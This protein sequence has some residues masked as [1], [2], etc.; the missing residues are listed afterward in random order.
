MRKLMRGGLV[1]LL[2][3]PAAMVLG[4]HSGGGSHGGGSS[5][6]GGS[7]GSGG[8]SSGGSHGGNTHG[9]GARIGGPHSGS[10][11]G[12]G[13][14]IGGSRGGGDHGGGSR[15]RSEHRGSH[16]RGRHRGRGWVVFGGPFWGPWDWWIWGCP[17]DPGC[18]G[19]PYVPDG[20]GEPG[21]Q[22]DDQDDWGMVDTEIW[23]D[24][25]RVY[26]EG[27]YI[28]A[29]EDFDGSRGFLYLRPG[30]YTLEFRLEGFHSASMD[31]NVEAGAKI[32][33]NRKL[34]RMRGSTEVARAK[35]PLPEGGLRRYW[36]KEDGRLVAYAGSEEAVRIRGDSDEA[37]DE[38]DDDADE[39][40][41]QAEPPRSPSSA[42]LQ[43]SLEPGD[44][45]VYLDDHYMG[46][47]A[48]ISRIEGGIP[49]P[50]GAHTITVT[51]PGFKS[52][53]LRVE[54]SRGES[55]SVK[56]SLDK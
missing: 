30:D 46:T 14:R 39:D 8:S 27:R 12:G 35:P 5:S 52:K 32:E 55:K 9:G 7:H 22:E 13:S 2:L 1:L 37:D 17:Y 56:L 36:G 10:P 34:H 45:V 42:R 38:T 3:V 16:D 29:A 28:G 47:A 24:Q 41:E 23:P 19:P 43:L 44:G 21:Y 26:L 40:S 6:G 53:T 4:Q 49:V 54:L 25:A 33:L 20:G 18:Y 31:L 15:F 48:K 51:R 11:H 50:P